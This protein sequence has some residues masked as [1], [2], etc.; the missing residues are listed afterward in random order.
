MAARISG[1]SRWLRAGFDVEN[2][3]DRSLP[4]WENRDRVAI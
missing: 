1:G 3:S 2:G 4:P